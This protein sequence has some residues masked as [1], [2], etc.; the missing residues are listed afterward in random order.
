MAGGQNRKRRVGWRAAAG[1]RRRE[2]AEHGRIDDQ[3]PRRR[4]GRSISDAST[5]GFPPPKL[6]PAS[7]AQINEWIGAAKAV[8]LDTGAYSASQLNPA[9]IKIIIQ[10]ESSGIPNNV[11]TWDS[12]WVNGI[13][14]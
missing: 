10:S 13:P 3:Q 1:R 14:S 12:N 11:N 6:P 5:D 9:D 2:H 4:S 8:M 7:A